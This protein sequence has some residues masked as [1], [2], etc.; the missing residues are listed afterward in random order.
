MCLFNERTEPRQSI[1]TLVIPVRLLKRLEKTT[2]KR[3]RLQRVSQ[4]S[5]KQ[6]LEYR[7]RAL[8]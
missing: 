1:S 5:L 2:V 4:S 8:L 7:S 3:F 6:A